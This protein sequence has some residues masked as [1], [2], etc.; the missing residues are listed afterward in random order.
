MARE[1]KVFSGLMHGRGRVQVRTI[2]AATSQKHAAELLGIGLSEL[3][4]WWSCTGN[5]TEL[6]AA[7]ACPGTVL[8]ASTT[9]SF[10][11]LPKE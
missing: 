5:E 3:R 9:T 10:D 2:V 6:A 11:F 4:G 7:L 8:Q 1:L